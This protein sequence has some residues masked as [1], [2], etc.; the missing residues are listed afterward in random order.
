MQKDWMKST[1]SYTFTEKDHKN[2]VKHNFS[3]VSKDASAEVIA[4]FGNILG[5]LTEGKLLDVTVATTDHVNVN[6][7]VKEPVPAAAPQA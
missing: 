5:A 6:E 7:P 1:A 3:N 2:G 4:K